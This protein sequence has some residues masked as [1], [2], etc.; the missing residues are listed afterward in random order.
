M[1]HLICEYF[2]ST[3]AEQSKKMSACDLINRMPLILCFGEGVCLIMRAQGIPYSI[4]EK[5]KNMIVKFLLI[6]KVVTDQESSMV[7]CDDTMKNAL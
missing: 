4:H 5:S 1:I 3:F 7:I 2:I 6:K